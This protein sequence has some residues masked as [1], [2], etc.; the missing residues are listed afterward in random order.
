MNNN[1]RM[2]VKSLEV[3]HFRGISTRKSIDLSSKFTL[4]WGENGTGKS[5]FVNALEYLFKDNLDGFNIRTINKR[6]AFVHKGS[7]EDDMEI[8]LT[9]DGGLSY[10]KNSRNPLPKKVIQ[11]FL[12]DNYSFLKASSFILT[13]RKL[14]N[15]IE[16]TPSDRYKSIIELCGFSE[17]EEMK[18][19]INSSKL[20]YSRLLKK[21]YSK[22]EDSTHELNTLLDTNLNTEE[23]FFSKINEI[24]SSNNFDPIDKETDLDE[25][26][27]NM[28]SKDLDIKNDIE[29][30]R[31]LYSKIHI[32]EISYQ[33]NL[34]LKDY[35]KINLN[36]TITL[37]AY[38]GLLKKSKEYLEIN[39]PSNCPVCNSKIDF[40]ELT[41]EI[42]DKLNNM[43]D[44]ISSIAVWKDELN[45]LKAKFKN[46][47]LN[48]EN[49]NQ[50][51]SDL[52]LDLIEFNYLN[53]LITDLNQLYEFKVSVIDLKDKYDLN[54]LKRALKRSK[55]LV[56]DKDNFLMDDENY[57]Q[58]I[59]SKSLITI[60]KSFR[61]LNSQKNKLNP[62]YELAMTIFNAYYNAK[63]EFINDII[64]NIQDDVKRHYKFLHG[65]DLINSPEISS[66][67]TRVNLYLNSFGD[68][69]DPRQFS[70]EGHIDSLGL[71]IF[72]A[73]MKEY[74]PL[75][76]IVL[77]DIVTT[78]D[79]SHKY[80]IARLLIEEFDDFNFFITTH[81]GLWV[82]QIKTLCRNYNIKCNEKFI[83]NWS[84]TEGPVIREKLD[85]PQL[86]KKYLDDAEYPA[87]VNTARQYLEYSTYNFCRKNKVSIR[88][89]DRY[90]LKELCDAC[91]ERSI[92]KSKNKRIGDLWSELLKNYFIVNTLSHFNNDSYFIHSGEIKQLCSIVLKLCPELNKIK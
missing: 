54:D 87:A 13:R 24:L 48:L 12:K 84:I 70:S 17:I 10:V 42:A 36:S 78:V 23:E 6:D 65:E 69:T 9:F 28:D 79:F 5:S 38:Y 77:D 90:Q 92:E 59:K 32:D 61:E 44:E 31:D 20:Y 53:S 88:I 41:S 29:N 21:I 35:E 71:C 49:L 33:L 64:C 18:N 52:S 72:L 75:K 56:D 34:V 80:E 47:I 89:L 39:G 7:N 74:N 11:D 66:N 58:I 40:K 19:V 46:L 86:I 91:R 85:Y 73:F 81:N 27:L 30:F 82:N 15:F 51:L 83:S 45:R 16:T 63:K 22:L 68:K 37:N 3:Q 14:L 57:Q 2:G 50:L 26:L 60:F 8:V 25:Y 62:K 4:L 1:D 43:D 67:G 76:L 55:S